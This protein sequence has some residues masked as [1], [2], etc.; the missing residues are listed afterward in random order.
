MISSDCTN[1]PRPPLM[2]RPNDRSSIGN[3]TSASTMPSAPLQPVRSRRNRKERAIVT[4][5]DS[6]MI[7]NTKYAGP[8]VSVRSEEHT[9]ELQSLM[10]H[11]YAVFCLKT[12]K[13]KEPHN[14]A[15]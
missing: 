7:G 8:M 10:R 12:K 3:A 9:S 14:I 15:Y 4:T 5:G 1:Q 13:K 6:E 11:S 2:P